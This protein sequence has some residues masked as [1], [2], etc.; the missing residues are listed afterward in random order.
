M[1][2][3]DTPPI[4][5]RLKGELKAYRAVTARREVDLA[6]SIAKEQALGKAGAARLTGEA[7]IGAAGLA[8]EGAIG[9]AGERARGW[10]G[11]AKQ[12]KLGTMYGADVGART[13]LALGR[14]TT[15]RAFGVAKE[16]AGSAFD[17]QTLKT[18]EAR[19][20]SIA[21]LLGEGYT[22]PEIAKMLGG[23]GLAEAGGITDLPDDELSA[24]IAAQRGEREPGDEEA[25]AEAVSRY[26][27]TDRTPSA[28]EVRQRAEGRLSAVRER[29]RRAKEYRESY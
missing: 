19:R 10:I 1:A 13:D 6:L 29:I 23:R 14:E 20:K 24:L 3:P 16:E 18:E 11:A 25:E 4:L 9:A 5:G 15:R 17:V 2:W 21:T 7:T 28:F 8:K 26:F 22:L 27:S 12:G